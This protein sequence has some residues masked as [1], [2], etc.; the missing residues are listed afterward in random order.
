MIRSR[1]NNPLASAL[2]IRRCMNSRLSSRPLNYFILLAA[3]LSVTIFLTARFLRKGAATENE[4]TIASHT[5]AESEAKAKNAGAT[6]TTTPE[7]A[8]T[9][10]D[11]TIKEFV[12]TWNQG[13]AEDIARL[14]MSDGT[15][16]T[17]NGSQIQSRDEIKK[18]LTEKRAGVLK[19]TILTNTVEEVT[20]PDP[21]TALVHGTYK[22]DGIKILGVG[23]STT[24]LY[25][26]RQ[27]KRD[28]R[29]FI[30]RAEL[31]GRDRG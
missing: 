12:R 26:L 5:P 19:E 3:F 16:I 21:N 10:P 29:W 11:T 1:L 6:G 2:L 30:S 25:K 24:G 15:L 14:F 9:P 7:P 18:T 31:M 27:V 22:L 20:R 23:T 4:P 8:E 13:S 28:G 17:P